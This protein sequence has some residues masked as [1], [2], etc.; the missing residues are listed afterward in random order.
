MHINT[1]S[2]RLWDFLSCRFSFSNWDKSRVCHQVPLILLPT[3]STSLPPRKLSKKILSLCIRGLCPCEKTLQEVIS[4]LIFACF[5]F[6]SLARHLLYLKKITLLYPMASKCLCINT[7]T[8]HSAHTSL[9]C[10]QSVPVQSLAV[11]LTV[12][13]KTHIITQWLDLFFLIAR[14]V[15]LHVSRVT[16]PEALVVL[17]LQQTLFKFLTKTLSSMKPVYKTYMIVANKASSLTLM[18]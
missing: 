9:N 2:K 10:G 11:Q 3:V 18:N 1:Q 17:L 14:S 6:R 5:F 8:R 4:F 7:K 13:T 16:V 12:Q 15:K